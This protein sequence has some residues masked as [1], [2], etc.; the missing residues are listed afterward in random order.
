MRR[1]N[2]SQSKPIRAQTWAQFGAHSR[3]T[4]LNA[5]WGLVLKN[6]WGVGTKGPDFPLARAADA[7][8]E[9]VMRGSS[10]A[11]RARWPAQRLRGH[12]RM[13]VLLA[14]IAKTWCKIGMFAATLPMNHGEKANSQVQRGLILKNVSGV[15]TKWQYFVEHSSTF[16]RSRAWWRS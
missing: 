7:I 2:L 10:R 3:P 8:P 4:L 5:T 1:A 6:V 13:R 11:L 15:R 14:Q 9:K 12:F 16:A